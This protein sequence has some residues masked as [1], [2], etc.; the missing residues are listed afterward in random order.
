LVGNTY[1]EDGRYKGEGLSMSHKTKDGWAIPKTVIISDYYN[2]HEYVNFCL[3][4]NEK[5]LLMAVERLDSYGEQDLYVSFLQEDETWGKPINMGNVINT[6]QSEFSPFIAADGKTL[7]F[8]SEGHAGYGSADIFVSKRLDDTWQNWTKPL[9][10]GPTINTPQWDAYFTMGSQVAE[11]YMVS[12]HTGYGNLDIFQVFLDKKDALVAASSISPEQVA[13]VKG[14]VFDAHSQKP[15]EAQLIY[16]DLETGKEMG[17]ARSHPATGFFQIP[18]PYGKNYGLTAL[19]PYYIAASEQLYATSNNDSSAIYQKNIYLSPLKK[20]EST[21]VNNLFFERGT[22]NILPS[23]YAELNR[24]ASL[25]LQHPRMEI[26]I[27]GHTDSIG[28]SR[29]LMTLSNK[30]AEAVKQYL[31]EQGVKAER[32]TE[33]GYGANRPIAPNDTEVGRKKNRR[34]TF[35]I[36]K[37]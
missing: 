26:R 24:L 27:E 36:T 14:Y 5:T 8:A 18:L 15:L 32:M 20:G 25:L 21:Q 7:Y 30:R 22:A 10:L 9:N 4:P 17:S 23:S 28:D 35:T 3:A 2:D 6:H 31:T 1:H 11:A 33:K 13:W 12:N 19:A 16:E 37:I 29:V 34:V